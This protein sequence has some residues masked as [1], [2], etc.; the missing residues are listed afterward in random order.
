MHEVD[1]RIPAGIIDQ[2][3]FAGE[4][5]GLF[6]TDFDTQA[7]MAALGKIDDVLT[8]EFFITGPGLFPLELDDMGRAGS[9][10]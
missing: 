6:R 1:N 7:A 9:G 5:K 2:F 3:I 8:T 10:A 4:F